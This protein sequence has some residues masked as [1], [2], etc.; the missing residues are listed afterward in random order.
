V[1][2]GEPGRKIKQGLAALIPN[3][4]ASVNKGMRQKGRMFL[5]RTGRM[6]RQARQE[7]KTRI[8]CADP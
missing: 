4:E 5:F 8:S 2:C 3:G 7:D 6:L 1:E